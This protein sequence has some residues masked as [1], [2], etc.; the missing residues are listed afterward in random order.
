[1]FTPR[2][3]G[4]QLGVSY[5]PNVDSVG[6]NRQTF[7]LNTDEDVAD[8][9]HVFGAGVNFVESFNAVDI[10]VFAGAEWANLEE[11]GGFGA[12]IDDLESYQGGIN[13]GFGGF[14]VGGSLRYSNAVGGLGAILPISFAASDEVDNWFWDAGA[15]YST[16][17][18]TV[19]LTYSQSRLDIDDLDADQTRHMVEAGVSYA[20]SPGVTLTGALQYMHDD[21]DSPIGDLKTEG[22]GGTVGTK[23]S[24]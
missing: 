20:L 2:F 24:F 23:L 18:V 16:G 6:G 10:A 7:G 1:Y 15:T 8:Y 21:I 14:T 5:T 19:G 3:G 13:V 11:D 12:Y 9:N 17:A 4:F 22:Y